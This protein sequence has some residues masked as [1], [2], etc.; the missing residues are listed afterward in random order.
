MS[1]SLVPAVGRRQGLTRDESWF[2]SAVWLRRIVGLLW[3]IDG[4]LQ[5]QPA[6]FTMNMINGIM[7]PVS[8]GQPAPIAANLKWIIAFTTQNLVPINWGIVLLQVVLGLCFISGRWVKAAAVVSVV[9]ALVVWYAGEGMSM[10]FTGQGS[11]LTG[12]P[13]SVLLY[14]LLTLIFFLDW[15]DSDK[16]SA[17]SRSRRQVRWAL[18]AFWGFAGLLQLQPYWWQAKQISGVI[19]GLYS[20]GT[21]S[22]VLV[23]PSLH[24][25]ARVTSGIEVPLNLVLVAVFLIVG[26]GL[27]F[28]RPAQLK[29]W[30]IASIALSLIIWWFSQDL[31]MAL[32]G[33]ATDPNSGPLLVLLAG[34]CWTTAPRSVARARAAA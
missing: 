33:M 11:A 5:L 30:L 26:L 16:D 22:G 28:A 13:G 14:A 25:A 17:S 12:A 21:L 6:M 3:L 34:T 4:L 27:F 29:P 8:Q 1:E 31:G 10:L 18:A 2:I 20:P 9:W 24:W 32:T 15:G 7:A 23:D 19:G